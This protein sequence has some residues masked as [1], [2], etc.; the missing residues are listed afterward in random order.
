MALRR[1]LIMRTPTRAALART[2]LNFGLAFAAA[3][4]TAHGPVYDVTSLQREVDQQYLRP[5]GKSLQVA[6]TAEP[7]LLSGALGHALRHQYLMAGSDPARITQLQNIERATRSYISYFAQRYGTYTAYRLP[8]GRRLGPQDLL[9]NFQAA[10]QGKDD[11]YFAQNYG[12]VH[13]APGVAPGLDTG[14]YGFRRSET[15]PQ[16]PPGGAIDLLGQKAPPAS[17]PGIVPT[18]PLPKPPPATR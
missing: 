11:V 4:A 13:A 3:I 16:Q 6:Q 15:A 10:L 8:D 7:L 18:N 14:S 1:S 2:L 17:M 12:I 5:R 9:D